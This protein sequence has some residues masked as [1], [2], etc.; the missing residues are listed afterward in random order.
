MDLPVPSFEAHGLLLR[1]KKRIP[2]M[3]GDN[4]LPSYEYISRGYVIVPWRICCDPHGLI[5]VW[6]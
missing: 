1:R 6:G 4:Y 2:P 5:V 3:K